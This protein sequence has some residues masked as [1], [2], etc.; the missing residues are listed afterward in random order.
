MAFHPYPHLIREVFNLLRFGPPL[1]LTPALPWTWIDHP[2][3]GLLPATHSP[4]SD[5]LSLRLHLSRLNLAAHSNSLTHYA[6]GTRSPL[7]GLP[8]ETVRPSIGLPQF[9]GTRF[10]VLFTPLYGVLF[11]FPSRYSFTIGH[12]LVFSLGRWSSQL[13][14][15]F[16]VPRGTRMKHPGSPTG[17]A[18]GALT[19]CGPPSQTLRLP[20]GFLTPRER[21]S[22]LQCSPTTPDLQRLRAI[23]QTGFGL[24]PL[25]S[26]LLGE[27]RLIS[28]PAGTEMFH[29]PALASVTYGFSKG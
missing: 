25:R 6:K 24:F 11:T 13:P 12:Q 2:V 19:L 27:S 28:V 18:Y 21:R 9:V 20:I 17:F 3:S 4:C 8:A 23:T 16:P 10:Q 14:T 22:A 5:S 15:G 7:P 26:P 1:G 29:F